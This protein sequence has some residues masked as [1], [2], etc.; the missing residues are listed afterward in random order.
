MYLLEILMR[1]RHTWLRLATLAVVYLLLAGSVLAQP[2]SVFWE[3]W[4]VVIDN[5]DTTANRFDVTEITDVWFTGSFT[6]GSRVIALNN[7]DAIQDV[8]VREAGRPLQQACTEQPGTFCVTNTRDGLQIR[9]VFFEPIT[10]R[11]QR[12]EIAYTVVGALRIYEGG[13]QIW[14][15]AIPQE[16]FGFSIGAS[17]I[18]IQMPPGYGPREGIDPVE[19]FG[20]PATITV[21]GSTVTAQATGVIGGNDRFEIRMQYPHDPQAQ[22]PGW[23]PSFDAQRAIFENVQPLLD[24]AAL[25]LAALIGL[26]GPLAM[27]A[28]WYQRGRDPRIGSVPAFLSD[29]PSDLPPALVGALIDEKVDT[30]DVMSTIIDLG[31]NGYLVIEEELTSAMFGMSKKR[32]HTFKRT[33]KTDAG[34]RRFERR[35]L[36]QLFSSNQMEVSLDALKDTFYAAIPKVQDDLYA[37]LVSEGFFRRKPNETRDFWN[38]VAVGLFVVAGVIFIA[39]FAIFETI[40]PVTSLVPLALFVTGAAVSF[41]GTRMP[42]KT[43]KGAEE[44]ARWQA[45][46]KY[47]RYLEDYDSV[48]AAADRFSA[49]LPYAV[50]FGLDRSWVRKFSALERVPIPNWYYPTH[51][52]QRYRGGYRPGTP[53][54]PA[55]YGGLAR[56]GEG[57]S[58]DT[59]SEGLAGGLQSMSDGLTDML[60]SASRVITSKPQSSGS[61]GRWSGGGFSGGGFSGGGSS[62][63][64]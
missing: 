27:F 64:G 37:D 10:D 40:T 8:R 47:M 17:T 9:Y 25:A 39:G 59:M 4:D 58:L 46:Y 12:F 45:F 5:V 2:R 20:T 11:S 32:E 33:D 28:I 24:L 43:R 49:Y 19:V 52:G 53:L 38:T 13:D 36:D 21:R 30:R 22:V 18:T 51:I 31:H 62:G 29:P 48:E 61:G 63:F 60:D 42:S 26:G 16:H 57:M 6:F 34:L 44:A 50:A 15:A 41:F 55:D 1:T 35:V 7:L 23:Q 54:P 3:R 56:A 14:W